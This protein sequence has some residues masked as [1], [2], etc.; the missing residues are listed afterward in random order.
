MFAAFT[1]KPDNKVY[2]VENPRVPLNERNP[3]R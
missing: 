2:T 1:A 3:R